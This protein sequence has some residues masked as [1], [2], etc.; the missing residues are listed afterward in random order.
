MSR[1]SI[2]RQ[3][4]VAAVLESFL[5]EETDNLSTNLFDGLEEVAETIDKMVNEIL[6]SLQDTQ[7]ENEDFKA[8]IERLEAKIEELEESK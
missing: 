6:G 1:Q 2:G 8:E 3:T 4:D 7:A 5:D